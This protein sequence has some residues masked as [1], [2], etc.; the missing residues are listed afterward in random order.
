MRTIRVKVAIWSALA[1]TVILSV[2]FYA[3]YVLL[4]SSLINDLDKLNKAEFEQISSRL[5]HVDSVLDA[6]Y[7]ELR[8]RETSEYAGTLFYI[9]IWDRYGEILFSSPNIKQEFIGGKDLPEKGTIN[10]VHLGEIRVGVFNAGVYT[11]VI[12]TPEGSVQIALNDF[13]NISIALSIVMLIMSG[14]IGYGLSRITLLPIVSIQ[15]TA[16]KITSDNLKERIPAATSSTEM[17]NLV[18][19]LNGMFDRIESGFNQVRQF[20]GEA[21]HEL[22][23]PLSIIRLHSER[24]LSNG[25]LSEQSK[26][27]IQE[28]LIEVDRLTRVIE[29]L[30]FISR[31]ESGNIPL[32][33]ISANPQQFFDGFHQDAEILADSYGIKLNINHH[34]EGEVEFEPKW[35]RQVLLN[36]LMN[37]IHVS[38]PHGEIIIQSELNKN[39]WKINVMDQGPGLEEVNLTRIFDRFVRIKNDKHTP[40]TGLGLSICQ[41][42]I[43][44]HGG[45]ISAKNNIN[46][47]GLNVE[48]I[49]YRR[50]I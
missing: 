39:E 23:T 37:G 9:E 1:S 15:D 50:P 33:L 11:I 49:I 28:Q 26:L 48:V 27:I 22:K 6:P 35:I 24:L 18:Q 46:R 44:L 20:T 2:L 10:H 43:Q 7:V 25:S 5:G 40:G 38:P 16:R 4:K 14:L 3:G 45:K 34:G 36:I 19:L 30:L 41:S 21:S 17:N 47:Q 29:Q 8:M 13:R 42:L 31:A 12:G 32:K